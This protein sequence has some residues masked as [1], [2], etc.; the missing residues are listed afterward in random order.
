VHLPF[1]QQL[2]DRGADIAALAAASPAAATATRTAWAE[3]EP[4]TGIESKLESA[5]GAEAAARSEAGIAVEAGGVLAQMVAKVFAE[6]ATGL[7]ALLMKRAPI[8]RA[9]AKSAGRRGEWVG[10]EWF[11]TYV[12]KH[13]MY[14][15]YVDDISEPIAMQRRIG[16]VLATHATR[17]TPG[18]DAAQ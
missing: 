3:A 6:L 16:V 2:E 8:A 14:F 11:L 15:R 4:A 7:P 17:T 5:A 13:G 9:E 1:G 18:A 10:H 12:G